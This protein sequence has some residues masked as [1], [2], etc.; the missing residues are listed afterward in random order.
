MA[1]TRIYMDADDKNVAALVIF[2]NSGSYFYDKT[3]TE[4]V[5]TK[6]YVHLFA[7]GVVIATVADGVVTAYTRPIGVSGVNT[8][9]AFVMA[10]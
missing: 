10:E 5:E 9:P 3:F 1:K 7:N 4:A 8:T 6:D 2:A